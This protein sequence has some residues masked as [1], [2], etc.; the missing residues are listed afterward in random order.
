MVSVSV[1]PR[2]V[3]IGR[4]G[5][6]KGSGPV[7]TLFFIPFSYILDETVIRPGGAVCPLSCLTAEQRKGPLCAPAREAQIPQTGDAGRSRQGPALDAR[8]GPA[9]D[10]R[11]GFNEKAQDLLLGQL[12]I[13]ERIM[14]S[15]GLS[16]L[17]FPKQKGP[18][19]S[20]LSYSLCNL[21]DDHS[22]GF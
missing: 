14:A 19:T 17:P 5:P 4:E 6:A 18:P 9:L 20:S 11:Q 3:G 1:R 10:G 2:L 7:L 16:S 12:L 22:Q 15:K 13:L 8:Q 21:Q